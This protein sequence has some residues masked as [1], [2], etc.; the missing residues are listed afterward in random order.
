MRPQFLKHR[1]KVLINQQG[2][3]A[4]FTDKRKVRAV[5]LDVDGTLYHQLPLRY[6][7]AL[8]LST[9]P[10]A[11][12]SF[13]SAYRIWRSLAYFRWV[14]EEL[15]GL[16][17][18]ES[19][20]AELQYTEVA[21]QVGMA[22]EDIEE[23]VSEWMLWRPL[24][25]LTICRR[26]NIAKFFS[27][28]GDKGMQ[29]GVFSDY[30]VIEKIS[31]LGLSPW[32]S[33]ALCATDPEIDALKPHPKG[34]LRAC[35]LWGLLPEEVLYVGDRPEVDAIGA[36]SAGMPCAI[37]CSRGGALHQMSPS[38]PYLSCTSFNDLQHFLTT[39]AE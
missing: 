21:R 10:F 27:F 5:L 19:C 26:R 15:R 6:L 37:L 29:I 7:M 3:S 25:Y 14:R 8:E 31:S 39:I 11:M 2:Y 34:F 35:A 24:K 38:R 1:Q 17:Q 36:A 12:R 16:R 9:L 33:V 32:V 23:I 4:F 13:T 22:P 20:L 18:P 30:P 28:L